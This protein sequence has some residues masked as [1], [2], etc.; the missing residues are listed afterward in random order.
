MCRAKKEAEL[1]KRFSG[2]YMEKDEVARQEEER[3]AA[4]LEKSRQEDLKVIVSHFVKSILSL[5]FHTLKWFLMLRLA[6]P[7]TPEDLKSRFVATVRH[8]L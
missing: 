5:G 2:I 3:K 4:A 6:P 8:E 1:E 7:V